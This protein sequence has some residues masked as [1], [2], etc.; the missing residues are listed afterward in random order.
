MWLSVT[1]HS[2]F[3]LRPW[4]MDTVDRLG[5]RQSCGTLESS[6]RVWGRRMI[7]SSAGY[8]PCP[9]CVPWSQR[10]DYT[11][12]KLIDSKDLNLTDIEDDDSNE[13]Q[14]K[15]TV[16]T[17]ERRL[18]IKQAMQNRGPLAQEHRRKI[19]NSV[20]ARYASDPSLRQV[21][22]RKRCSVCGQEGHNKKTCP[23]LSGSLVLVQRRG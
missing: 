19:S 7:K 20:R 18:A 5:P 11:P 13:K 21:G 8:L 23:Q 4:E 2:R 16:M 9:V 17:E 6:A 3:C 22:K 10:P 12:R 15:P 1:C 14:R